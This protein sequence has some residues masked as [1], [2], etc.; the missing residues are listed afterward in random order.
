MK[1]FLN[2]FNNKLLNLPGSIKVSKLK[3]YISHNLCIPI[4]SQ[5]LQFSGKILSDNLSLKDYSI[6]K[7][8]TIYLNIRMLGGTNSVKGFPN[9]GNIIILFIISFTLSGITYYIFFLIMQTILFQNLAIR[10][11]T[12]LETI[13]NSFL[14]SIT[15]GFTY[16]QA[17][18]ADIKGKI[19]KQ[20]GGLINNWQLIFTL[21]VFIYLSIFTAISVTYLSTFFCDHQPSYWIF[22]A[23]LTTLPILFIINVLLY[24]FRIKHRMISM[25]TAFFIN[26]GAFLIAA[27]IL[28]I[29]MIF[30]PIT[31][32]TPRFSLWTYVF[33]ISV[34]IAIILFFMMDGLPKYN[35]FIRVLIYFAI[36]LA[37]ICI[38]Y[39][40]F[41]VYNNYNLCK[42]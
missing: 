10:D 5:I 16:P 33:P 4:D 13:K 21:S 42:N 36:F 1:I 30:V 25:N 24:R 20:I 22:I 26:I 29:L 31:T 9:I 23:S 2:Y 40:L 37:F 12:N 17:T 19:L 15:Q 35:K 39:I 38:P 3:K 34:S 41:Y 6:K 28:L 7:Y 8:S 27:M 18:H 11:C 14:F 32:Q